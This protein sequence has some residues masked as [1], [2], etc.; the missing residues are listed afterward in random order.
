MTVDLLSAWLKRWLVKCNLSLRSNHLQVAQTTQRS[1]LPFLSSIIEIS[2]AHNALD[3]PVNLLQPILGNPVLS[4]R[5]ETFCFLLPGPPL[6]CIL[7]AD[8]CP[9]ATLEQTLIGGLHISV[10]LP[11]F[12]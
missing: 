2:V 8:C 9:N 11:Q 5:V 3:R 4:H 1:A 7:S 12:C 10:T 6:Y